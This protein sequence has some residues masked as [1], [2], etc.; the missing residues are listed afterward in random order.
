MKGQ[1][2]GKKCSLYRGFDVSRFFSFFYRWQRKRIS[3]VIPRSS[4]IEVAKLRFHFNFNLELNIGRGM[5][6]EQP[7]MLGERKNMALA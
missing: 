1:G 6:E 2:I 3:F 5:G 4:L 7:F